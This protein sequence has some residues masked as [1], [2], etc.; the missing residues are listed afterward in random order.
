MRLIALIRRLAAA[1]ADRRASRIPALVFGAALLAAATGCASSS[2]GRSGVEQASRSKS[3]VIT[4]EEIGGAHWQSV[5]ELVQTLRPRWLSTH[6]PDSILG[7]TA[8]V[9]VHL[10]DNRLGGVESLRNIAV[11]G[12]TSLRFVDPVTAA[13]RWGGDHANGAIIITTR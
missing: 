5:Y 7:Q 10:D 8:P 3:D 1:R 13:G 6:G 4:E 9:Q 11:S 12:I 2:G